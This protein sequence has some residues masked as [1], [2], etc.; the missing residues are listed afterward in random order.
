MT[1]P[2]TS[3][4]WIHFSIACSALIGVA[5][6]A[7]NSPPPAQPDISGLPPARGVYYHA[8]NEWVSLPYTVLMPFAEGKNAALEVLNVGSD[9]TVVE[10]PGPRAAVQ[11]G[12][13]PRPVFY[14]HD[15]SPSNLY[16]VRAI[17]KE[18]YREIRMP[19]SIHFRRWAHFRDQ[20]ITA[21]EVQPLGGDV[22]AV[23]PHTDLQAGE[24]A[25][26]SVV[27]PGNYWIRLGFDFGV[28]GVSGH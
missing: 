2:M 15:I 13:D 26:A 11:I 9:H 24:Y 17:S 16:L 25:L 27:Q 21:L 19:I 22:I 28:G 14:L 6:L 20:D 3:R 23:R 8:S 1:N 10:I 4:R 12:N 18:D 7:Q 5:L